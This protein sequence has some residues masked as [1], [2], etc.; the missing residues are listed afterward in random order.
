MWIALKPLILAAFL[1]LSAICGAPASQMLLGL[2]TGSTVTPGMTTPLISGGS[3]SGSLT[4]A[5][6]WYLAVGAGYNA[7]YNATYGA[8]GDVISLSGTIS[9][10]S[11]QLT[12]ANVAGGSSSWTVTRAR[13]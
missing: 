8:S 3:N 13:S 2:G 5:A 7:V 11:V 12:T 10:L 4:N 9:N 6:T 1:L